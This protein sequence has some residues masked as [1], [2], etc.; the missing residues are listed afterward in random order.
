M[1]DTLS[2]FQTRFETFNKQTA[3]LKRKSSQISL[4]RILT[5]V[6]GVILSVM[7]ANNNQAQILWL[8]ILISL[9][10]FL[11]LIKWHHL[12]K[13]ELELNSA[14]KEVNRDET[15]RVLLDLK[16]LDDGMEFHDPNHP[17]HEDLDIFGRHSL[18]QLINRTST[19]EGKQVLASW[20]SYSSVEQGKNRQSAIEELK[21]KVEFRQLFEA[22]GRINSLKDHVNKG[23]FN[24]LKESDQLTYGRLYLILLFI[25]PALTLGSII[26]SILELTVMGLP[27]LIILIYWLVLGSVSKRLLDITRTTENGYK[28]ISTL[29]SQLLLIEN[30]SFNTNELLDLKSGILSKHSS[31]SDKI[32]QLKFLL[33]SLHSRFNLM[34][35]LL[36]S[37]LL[38]DVFW[39]I[40]ITNWKT[41]N[42]LEI[43]RWF[44]VTAEFDALSSI[45]G[46]A[47]AEPNF[48]YPE[49]VEEQFSIKALSLGHPLISQ[50]KRVANDFRFEGKGGI[51]LITGSNMSGKSTFLRTLGINVVLSQLGAPVCSKEFEIG[52]MQVFTSMRTRDELEENVSSFYAELKRLKQLLETIN[53]EVPTLFMIDEVLKGTNSDD[54]HK[55]AL[56]LI[57]QL[58]KTNAFGLVSTHDLVLGGITNELSGVRNYSFNS[59]IENEEILFDYQLTPGICKS[60]N[61]TQLMKNMGIE[62]PN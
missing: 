14:L 59:R 42:E 16:A 4:L 40:K 17:F 31:A 25:L 33:D 50:N 44:E 36:N 10:L 30:E 8:I 23:F 5:V 53:D 62:I 13:N 9:I 24:W 29:K 46:F 35:W 49:L 54:R 27:L 41:K 48:V 60:F 51:C 26:T 19:P 55:G 3:L 38:T 61:A 47:F 22:N 56:A 2:F 7:A 12:N 58:N 28:S 6:I 1:K 52:P 57:K 11:I 20:M 37:I 45:A 15:Y 34:Y 18:F 21:N 39:L 43:Q 32:G